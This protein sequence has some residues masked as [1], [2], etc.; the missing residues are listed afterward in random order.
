MKEDGCMN[1][2]KTH[3]KCDNQNDEGKMVCKKFIEVTKHC[4][5]K[6]PQIL[7]STVEEVVGDPISTL[8]DPLFDAMDFSSFVPPE[9]SDKDFL[10]ELKELDEIFQVPSKIFPLIFGGPRPFDPHTFGKNP[11]I[12]GPNPFGSNTNSPNQSN[13]NPDFP[14]PEHW[15]KKN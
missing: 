6:E 4:V 2:T 13:R 14:E 3:L 1:L 15:R 12:F 10:R 9:T 8:N 7:S 11:D 5:N